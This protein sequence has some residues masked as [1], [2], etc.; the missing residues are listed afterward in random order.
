M[1]QSPALTYLCRAN[2]VLLMFTEGSSSNG[3]WSVS[4]RSG[5]RGG[6]GAAVTPDLWS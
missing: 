1:V 3:Q 2:N 5:R 4:F 6:A